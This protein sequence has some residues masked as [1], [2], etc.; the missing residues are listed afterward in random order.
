MSVLNNPRFLAAKTALVTEV[1]R[2]LKEFG[3][4]T[5]RGEWVV[6]IGRLRTQLQHKVLGSVLE[7]LLDLL[8][9]REKCEWDEMPL[10][11][12]VKDP[13]YPSK[14]NLW[15]ERQDYLITAKCLEVMGSAFINN[16]GSVAA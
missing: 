8:A 16:F 5:D 3:L 12:R 4:D 13:D 7:E 2:H 11:V 1:G 6:M 15:L 14:K 9:D 10:E